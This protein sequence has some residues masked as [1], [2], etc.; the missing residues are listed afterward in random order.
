MAE[1]VKA[2][3]AHH[4]VKM[5]PCKTAAPRL[6]VGLSLRVS[7]GSKAAPSFVVCVLPPGH[8]AGGLA[9]A[10]TPGRRP[11]G[12]FPPGR[13]GRARGRRRGPPPRGGLGMASGFRH[14]AAPPA[15][16]C[17]AGARPRFRPGRWWGVG[18]RDAFF[19]A[20]LAGLN[21]HTMVVLFPSVPQNS[22]YLNQRFPCGGGSCGH[23]PPNTPTPSIHTR[24]LHEPHFLLCLLLG[25]P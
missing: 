9:G 14:S 22:L 20:P 4:Q 12:C 24:S 11:G 5:G 7:G 25:A 17:L 23:G 1:N 8:V 21:S 10:K 2:R 6:I 19:E 16:T 13:R 15:R 3:A 18:W